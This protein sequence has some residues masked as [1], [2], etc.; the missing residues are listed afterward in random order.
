[1]VYMSGA[2]AARHTASVSNNT[3]IFGIMEGTVSCT[4]RP[5]AACIAIHTR[6]ANTRIQ[7]SPN[8]VFGLT[9]MKQKGA[10]SKNPACSGGVGKAAVIRQREC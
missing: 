7:W 1:M 8:Y 5:R 3:K 6:G 4:N 9:Q 2:K 10:L